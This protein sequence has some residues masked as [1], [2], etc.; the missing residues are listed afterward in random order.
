LLCKNFVSFLVSATP[1]ILNLFFSKSYWVNILVT[2]RW[3]KSF[4]EGR[5]MGWQIVKETVWKGFQPFIY[6]LLFCLPLENP[7]WK[8]GGRERSCC[9]L[10]RRERTRGP[11]V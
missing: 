2:H 1:S 6:P 8:E 10:V 4:Q 7:K 5:K 3:G 11:F 9:S